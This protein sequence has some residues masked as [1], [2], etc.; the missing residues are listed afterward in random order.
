MRAGA[1]AGCR[2]STSRS[3]YGCGTTTRASSWFYRVLVGLPSSGEV[4]NLSLSS[5]LTNS[6]SESIFAGL[7]DIS[8]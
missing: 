8:Y 4:E 1:L 6:G 5:E 2:W 7:L 3:G